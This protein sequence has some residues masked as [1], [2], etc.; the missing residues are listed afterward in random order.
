MLVW[1]GVATDTRVRRE[2]ATLA[3][4]GHQVHIVG[5][6]VPTDFRPE[7]GVT[8]STVGAGPRSAPRPRT[9]H[10]SAARWLLLE[11]YVRRRMAAWRAAAYADG[12][13]HDADVVHAHDLSALPV[14]ARLARRWQVPLIYDSHELWSGRP[15]EG[16]RWLG[17]SRAD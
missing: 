15:R 2:A 9:P 13:N 3:A 6:A 8:V 1:T 11:P 4:A 17:L 5:R 14:G 16:A 7:A 10:A 12:L